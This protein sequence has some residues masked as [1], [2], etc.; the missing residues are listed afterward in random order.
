MSSSVQ[1]NICGGNMI[2]I[3]DIFSDEGL[4]LETSA[5]ST[6]LAVHHISTNGYILHIAYA[7]PQLFYI[8]DK[9]AR[10]T[11]LYFPKVVI[12]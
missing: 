7:A 11:E 12:D 10:Y 8:M 2:D 1:Y 3:M 6:Q 5:T 4:S 9:C